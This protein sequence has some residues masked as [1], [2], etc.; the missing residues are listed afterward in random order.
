MWYWFTPTPLYIT[1]TIRKT[2]TTWQVTVRVQF[3]A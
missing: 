1:L 2:R 3:V